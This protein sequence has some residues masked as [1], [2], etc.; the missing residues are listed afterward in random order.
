MRPMYAFH[1]IQNA[2]I[3]FVIPWRKIV[4]GHSLG[5]RSIVIFNILKLSPCSW[6]YVS[7]HHLKLAV[8]GVLVV[9]SFVYVRVVKTSEFKPSK[10]WVYLCWKVLKTEWGACECVRNNNDVWMFACC[11]LEITR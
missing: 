9:I 4:W 6:G 1:T 3:K 5:I 2:N 8:I 11:F 7:Q 10:K